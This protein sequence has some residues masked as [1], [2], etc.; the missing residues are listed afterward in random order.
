MHMH[1]YTA[2]LVNDSQFNFL[3]KGIS[4]VFSLCKIDKERACAIDN[5]R[6]C[7]MEPLL[8]LKRIPSTMGFE[9]WLLE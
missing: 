6:V 3:F 2:R 5:E 9:L 8:Y 4:A 7:A 1:L